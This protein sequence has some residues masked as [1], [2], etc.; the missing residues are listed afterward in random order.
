[1]SYKV[2][3]SLEEKHAASEIMSLAESSSELVVNVVIPA[4]EFAHELH[5]HFQ[6]SKIQDCLDIITHFQGLLEYGTMPNGLNEEQLYRDIL[7]VFSQ[8]SE[9]TNVLVYPILITLVS[10][11]YRTGEV[12][13]K[14]FSDYS[15]LLNGLL[16]CLANDEAPFHAPDPQPFSDII[17]TLFGN[18][19]HDSADIRTGFVDWGGLDVLQERIKAR[20][21][22]ALNTAVCALHGRDL[23]FDMADFVNSI[24][25]TFGNKK[26]DW[27]PE[28]FLFL[29]QCLE[30][31]GDILLHE[32]G[33]DFDLLK[34]CRG[35]SDEKQIKYLYDL[36]MTC[37]TTGSEPDDTPENFGFGWFDPCSIDFESFADPF[38]RNHS[39]DLRCSFLDFLSDLVEE[40]PRCACFVA[41]KK[42]I[43]LTDDWMRSSG[44]QSSFNVRKKA[45][46]LLYLLVKQTVQTSTVTRLIMETC[47]PGS[48]CSLAVDAECDDLASDILDTM[49]ILL[50]VA[51]RDHWI[52]RQFLD[53]LDMQYV[54]DEIELLVDN[55]V[56]SE[57]ASPLLKRKGIIMLEWERAVNH[58]EE[59]HYGEE[60]DHYREQEWM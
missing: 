50:D 24:T 18:L 7:S 22:V 26:E 52:T 10:L 21:R 60:E 11:T 28:F 38:Y 25:E 39:E 17:M 5:T 54:W 46:S 23:Y 57:R 41:N 33:F 2:L 31:R 42:V 16:N 13:A 56:L 32:C 51:S 48:L 1:M 34:N 37:V 3:D 9:D 6:E 43:M 8:I 59:D 20:S 27:P 35:I 14:V 49:S 44:L 19:L 53:V 29:R 30:G 15:G 12:G 55:E 36:V 47:L 40:Q 58:E 4:N 45:A